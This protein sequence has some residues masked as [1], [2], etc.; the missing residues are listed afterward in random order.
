MDALEIRLA[1]PA[2]IESATELWVR[3]RWDSQPVLEERMGYTR[4]QNHEHFANVIARENSVWLALR[5]RRIVGLL[6]YRKGYVDQLFVE[7]SDQRTGVGRALL[8]KAKR[9]SPSR[10]ELYTHQANTRARA[11]YESQGFE[12]TAFGTSPPPECEP[13]VTYVWKPIT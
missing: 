7:P 1:A 11:F 2:E 6:A 13:D 10:L 5:G 3:S 9:L 8:E 12:A 4:E